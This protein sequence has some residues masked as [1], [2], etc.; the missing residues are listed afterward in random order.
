LA[1]PEQL[2][3]PQMGLD[4][5]FAPASGQSRPHRRL[6]NQIGRLALALSKSR[7]E[8]F[9]RFTSGYVIADLQALPDAIQRRA[10]LFQQDIKPGLV[11]ADGSAL[12]LVPGESGPIRRGGERPGQS[13]LH[14]GP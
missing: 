8:L 11:E 13:R 1:S 2:K 3:A 12:D 10:K 6:A 14:P 9:G 4:R 5:G 7:Q